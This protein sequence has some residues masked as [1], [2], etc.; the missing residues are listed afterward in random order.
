LAKPRIGVDYAGKWKDKPFRF[1]ARG[2]E[3]VSRP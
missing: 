2:N 3:F 1:L